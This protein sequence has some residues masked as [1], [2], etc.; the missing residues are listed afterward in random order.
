MSGLRA[1][2]RPLSFLRQRNELLLKEL[3]LCFHGQY[4]PLEF[5]FLILSPLFSI[6]IGVIVV[7]HRRRRGQKRWPLISQRGASFCFHRSVIT[8][9]NYT[10]SI[11]LMRRAKRYTFAPAIV[12]VIVIPQD[13]SR[14]SGGRSVADVSHSAARFLGTTIC[15]DYGK[16]S[17][18]FCGRNG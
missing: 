11:R 6:V 12:I 16:F 13:R 1:N 10:P 5:L 9:N 14:A 15:H 7:D 17:S 2:P 4:S 18:K 8:F 3:E